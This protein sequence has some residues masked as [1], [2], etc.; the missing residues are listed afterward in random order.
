MAH[1]PELRKEIRF[2]IKAVAAVKV[3]KSGQVFRTKTS[4]I[5][6]CGVLV[7]FEE[8]VQLMVGDEVSCE[9]NLP[10]TSDDSLPFWTV[11]TVVRVGDRSAA[12]EFRAGVFPSKNP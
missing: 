2:Q 10:E 6:G 8:P 7:H 3:A 1:H 12:F 9:C 4:D 11:G 5:S